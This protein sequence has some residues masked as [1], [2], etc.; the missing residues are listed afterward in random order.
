MS[1]TFTTTD[2]LATF[3]NATLW[4]IAGEPHYADT[5]VLYEQCQ[6][7]AT[8]ISSSSGGGQHEW[9]NM[10]M[11]PESMPRTP[12]PPGLTL[13][14]PVQS[15]FTPPLPAKMNDDKWNANTLKPVR[16]SN[17]WISSKPP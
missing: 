5:G 15:T 8:A 14:I 6:Q 17:K 12:T 11:P 7:N 13:L 3:P 2:A 4:N 16:T 1:A 9:P 10:I